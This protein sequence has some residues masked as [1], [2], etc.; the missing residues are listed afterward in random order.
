MRR[1]M[2]QEREK[3]VAER[4]PKNTTLVRVRADEAGAEDGVRL[5]A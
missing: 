1:H 2:G 3:P 4:V 5:A